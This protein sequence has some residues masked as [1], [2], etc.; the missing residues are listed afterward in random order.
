MIWLWDC[1]GREKQIDLQTATPNADNK[2]ILD[3][4]NNTIRKQ[5][6]ANQWRNGD[7]MV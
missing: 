4:I 7:R 6:G 3:N 2:S 1:G 5:T